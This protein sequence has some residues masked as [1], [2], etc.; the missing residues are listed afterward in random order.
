MSTFTR[1]QL[2]TRIHF[3]LLRSLGE[4]IDVGRML[5]ERDYADEVANVCRSLGDYALYELADRFDDTTAAEDVK[6]HLAEA[7]KAA[8]AALAQLGR[9]RSPSTPQ[10]LAWSQD[11][12]GF[13]LSR[14]LGT[15]GGEPAAARS[16][17]EHTARH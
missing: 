14:P 9:R 10:D 16:G 2:A 4:G 13:G 6:I 3:T 7:A 12:S 5:R 1:L 15:L 8:R 17:R 11:T